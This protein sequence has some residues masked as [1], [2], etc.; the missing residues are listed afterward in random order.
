MIVD[1]ADDTVKLHQ[2]VL[3]RRSRQE[4]LGRG[5]DGVTDPTSGL[6]VGLVHVS[7]T[8]RLVDNGSVP[9]DLLDLIGMARSE[10]V[11]ADDERVSTVEGVESAVLF[12]GEVCLSIQHCCGQVE[13]L[14][15]FL[16]PLL[17]EDG[18]HNEKNVATAFGPSLRQH[19]A[20]FDGL[21][22]ADFIR[23]D[24]AAR[25]RRPQREQSRFNLVG[26]QIDA[27]VGDGAREIFN[28]PR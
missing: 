25:Q 23:E 17:A 13:L 15:E 9:T 16:L 10:L 24:R 8:V 12:L 22:E 18:G 7:E 20:C 1:E 6:C 27:R 26:I 28:A 2:R 21:T 11:R 3:K 19:D 4:Q 5:A 14:A